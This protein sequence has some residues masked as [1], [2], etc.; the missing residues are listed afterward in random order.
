MPERI[1]IVTSFRPR[2]PLL[3]DD[4]TNANVRNK[5]HLSE[6]YY[7]WTLY[8]LDVISQR[9]RLAAVALQ[10]KYEKNV[11]DSDPEG[12]PGLCKVETVEWDEMQKWSEDI[13]KYIQATLHEMRPLGQ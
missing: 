1:T 4:S 5:S 10:E 7:Q 6:L 12:K 13:A 9:A 3:V 11:K 8:R 2:D